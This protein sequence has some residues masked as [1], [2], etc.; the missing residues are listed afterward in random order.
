MTKEEFREHLEELIIVGQNRRDDYER[1]G[2]FPPPS[3]HQPAIDKIMDIVFPSDYSRILDILETPE[4][5][6]KLAQSFHRGT[7]K[8]YD[9]VI[10]VDKNLGVSGTSELLVGTQGKPVNNLQDALAIAERYNFS[11]YWI[12]VINKKES[13]SQLRRKQMSFE[14]K[15]SP[16]DPS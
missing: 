3:E 13:L 4:G 6:R 11:E 7:C 16:D 10:H 2:K 8:P 5:R 14:D 12:H 9:H 15:K 1:T